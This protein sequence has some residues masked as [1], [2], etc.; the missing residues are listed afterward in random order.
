MKR[1]VAIVK[2]A[3]PREPP[4]MSVARRISPASPSGKIT[5]FMQT[6]LQ[7]VGASLIPPEDHARVASAAFGSLPP[8]EGK[9]NPARAWRRALGVFRSRIFW[10]K[11]AVPMGVAFVGM[12]LSVALVALRMPTL[13]RPALLGGALFAG[14]VF[15]VYWRASTHLVCS[16]L[17]DHNRWHTSV[18][19]HNGNSC[20][21]VH[22]T[23][24]GRAIEIRMS[25]EAIDCL[26]SELKAAGLSPLPDDYK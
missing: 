6:H 13:L 23:E 9:R 22:L 5:I 26:Q 7:F 24:A 19:H 25:Q 10:A 4:E 3:T 21:E 17:L 2:D 18:R 20:I 8:R 12:V 14:G 1:P 11:S 15:F 16:M